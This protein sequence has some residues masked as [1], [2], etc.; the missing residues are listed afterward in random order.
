MATKTKHGLPETKGMFKV[1][2][3][4]T[5]MQR[6]NTFKD[7]ETKS[8]K[9][10]NIL[11]FG[12][13]TAPESTVFVTVQGMERDEV[14]F[15]KRVEKGK[16][17]TKKVLWSNRFEDQGEGYGLIGVSVG[18]DKDDNGKNIVHTYTEFDAAEK[19]YEKLND[20]MPVFIQGEVEFSSFKRDNGEVSRNKRFNVRKIYNSNSIDFESP[21]FK[22]TSDFK[23]RIVF[24]SINKDTNSKEPR[25]LVEAK[26]V[27]YNTIEDVEFIIYNPTL[28]NQFRKG[29]KSYHAIDVWG[30]IVNK[31]DTDE[32]EET[33]SSVWGEEDS[34]KRI[35]KNYI[36]ELVITGADPDS[37]DKETYSEE[38]IEEAIKKLNSEGQ[39]EGG[40]WGESDNTDLDDS[41]LPW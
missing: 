41:D 5:G 38:A 33:S 9:K 23:Q 35:N 14:Y 3:F 19:I 36:R 15:S 29:L 1:R 18:L 6:D 21:D 28:A 12:V 11:N 27:T 16:V 22:E 30:K 26:I 40:V 39:V 34:F 7:I 24:M 10:M 2:G 37:I 8:G 20:E 17:E 25:F 13:E 31:V 32:V 4:V